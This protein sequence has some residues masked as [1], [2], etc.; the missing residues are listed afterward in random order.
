MATSSSLVTGEFRLI[1]R[2]ARKFSRPS[3]SVIRGIGDDAAVVDLSAGRHLVMTTDLLAEHV[4]FDLRTASFEDV[5][6][7]A[8]I[9]NLSDMAA[10]GARP[11]HVLVSIA[12]PGSCTESHI[13]RLYRG[14]MAACRPYRVSLIGGDTS[15]SSAG[16]FLSLTVTGSTPTG[17]TLLRSGARVGDL[18]YVTGTLGDSLVGLQLLSQRGRKTASRL[19][20]SMRRFLIAR[21]RRPV[22]HCRLGQLLSRHGLASAAIDLSDGLSGDLRHICAQSHVGAEIDCTAL[23][24]SP[25]LRAYARSTRT[26]PVRLALQGG[27][28]YELLFTVPPS[29]IRRLERLAA[30]PGRRLTRIGVTTPSRSGL[31]LIDASGHKIPIPLL[32]YDHFRSSSRRQT[33]PSSRARR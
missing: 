2:L 18:I 26:D 10:M 19:P 14:L 6:Y 21:H 7:K 23:P 8:A 33:S 1:R 17:F 27:E 30:Q 24:L 13:L 31:R 16:L 11:E 29:K 4:H 32:S 12:I 25:A 28:D 5:G 22:A 3:P 15:A 20:P 9:A